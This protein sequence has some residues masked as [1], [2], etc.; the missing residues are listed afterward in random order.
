MEK[1]FDWLSE[2]KYHVHLTAFLSMMLSAVV[3]FI[4]A[5]NDHDVLIWVFIGVVMFVNLIVMLTR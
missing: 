2:N 3:M 4:A 1:A 5:Q